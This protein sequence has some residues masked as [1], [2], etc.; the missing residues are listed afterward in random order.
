ML[1]AQTRARASARIAAVGAH[2]QGTLHDASS[3]NEVVDETV[4]ALAD[5]PVRDHR[6]R[7]HQLTEFR[8][9]ERQHSRLSERTHRG[10]P[11]SSPS[12]ERNLADE[13]A[14]TDRVVSAVHVDIERAIEQDEALAADITLD[15]EDAPGRDVH[16]RPQS[17]DST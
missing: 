12:E 1:D 8:T 11:T 6:E 9:R 16:S 2:D 3:Q 10:R 4:R 15:A 7:V 14:A 13:R 5:D 17:V